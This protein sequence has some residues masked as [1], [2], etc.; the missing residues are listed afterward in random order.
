MN[1]R[2]QVLDRLRTV[3]SMPSG[4]LGDES[5]NHVPP[6]GNRF[7]RKARSLRVVDCGRGA[8]FN[9][10][11]SYVQFGR[12]ARLRASSSSTGLFIDQTDRSISPIRSIVAFRF[13]ISTDWTSRQG[14]RA[15]K[16][17]LIL[18]S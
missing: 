9:R 5:G 1:F 12:A 11:E 13:S 3:F 8:A 4:K 6:Q 2:V 16:L 17:K 14:R 7:D 10:Q 18:A 15:V